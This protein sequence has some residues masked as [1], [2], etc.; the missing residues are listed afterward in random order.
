MIFGTLMEKHEEGETAK[1]GIPF[2][3]SRRMMKNQRA[4]ISRVR[5]QNRKERQSYVEATVV[6]LNMRTSTRGTSSGDEVGTGA[7]HQWH[8]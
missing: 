1:C 2:S 4:I 6:V 8:S 7:I 5:V 3:I